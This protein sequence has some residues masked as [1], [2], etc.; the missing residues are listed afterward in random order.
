M[1][2][3]RAKRLHQLGRRP[4]VGRCRGQ[5]R[6]DELVNRPQVDV[7]HR[8]PAC[9]QTG[10][11]GAEVLAR[12]DVVPRARVDHRPHRRGRRADDQVVVEHSYR[13]RDHRRGKHG[14]DLD[15]LVLR[16]RQPRG[17]F[18]KGPNQIEDT[19]HE[20]LHGFLISHLDHERGRRDAERLRHLGIQRDL[21]AERGENLL[22]ELHAQER[23]ELRHTLF[24]LLDVNLGRLHL[25]LLD[26]ADELGVQLLGA[27]DVDGVIQAGLARRVLEACERL[28]RPGDQPEHPV[29]RPAR[30]EPHRARRAAVG[31]DRRAEADRAQL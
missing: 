31:P 15:P 14:R 5:E 27:A 16:L 21:A 30:G 4:V 11:R 6:E 29:R 7:R 3:E 12:L 1:L 13:R 26:H 18:A 19:L 17:I 20:A 9:W 2:A 23:L 22:F 24:E 28:A 25:D 8:A 10:H